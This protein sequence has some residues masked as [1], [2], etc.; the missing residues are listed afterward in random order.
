M[1][2]DVAWSIDAG[3]D[4]VG[5]LRDR[6]LDHLD[7]TAPAA[8]LRATLAVLGLPD[9]APLAL[10]LRQHLYLLAKEAI[11]NAVRHAR[12]ATHLQV[13]LRRAGPTLELRV[14]NDGPT[15]ANPRPIPQGMGLRNM[16]RRAEA[17]GGQLTAG[18]VA[19]GGWGVLVRVP[20]PR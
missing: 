16:A 12:G 20:Y 11:T 13:E 10:H 4:T 15:P 3:A 6:L 14:Q 19:G 1:M 2:R 7:A 17:L 5:A 8:H 9:T 18:P